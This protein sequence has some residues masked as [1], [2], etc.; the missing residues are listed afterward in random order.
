[1]LHSFTTNIHPVSTTNVRK[2]VPIDFTQMLEIQ[3]TAI[4]V[5]LDE[6]S[7]ISNAIN[8]IKRIGLGAFELEMLINYS[9]LSDKDFLVTKIRDIS[10][11]ARSFSASVIEFKDISSAV[12]DKISRFNESNSSTLQISGPC[13]RSTLLHC[14]T[15]GDYEIWAQEANYL[16]ELLET[17]ILDTQRCVYY[18]ARMRSH[19]NTIG[20]VVA[21]DV[22]SLSGH[23][24]IFDEHVLLS[25]NIDTYVNQAHLRVEKASFILRTTGH[26]AEQLRLKLKGV[27]IETSKSLY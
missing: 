13:Q 2:A 3:Q 26:N 16:T 5:C 18:L 23:I 4:P 17:F 9:T 24:R 27:L 21:K 6:I 25:R 20:G 8:D 12:V 22:F 19:M 1:M 11:L 10:L 7:H 15:K 14:I